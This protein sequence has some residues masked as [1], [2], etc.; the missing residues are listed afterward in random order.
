MNDK[1]EK[2]EIQNTSSDETAVSQNPELHSMATGIGAV[3]GG[4]TGA[5]LGRAL[6]GR[7]GAAVG[8]V[9][10]AI[11]GGIAAQEIADLAEKLDQEIHPS[12]GLGAD[13]KPVELPSHYSWEELQALSK[14]QPESLH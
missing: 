4:I 11:A 3:S 8:G 5:A 13:T 14:P 12:L 1:P 10:G 9:T 2:S 6:G 7:V